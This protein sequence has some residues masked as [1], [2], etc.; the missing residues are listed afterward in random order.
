MKIEE[1]LRKLFNWMQKN[2]F[3][4]LDPFDTLS[5]IK[6]KELFPYFLR[7]LFNSKK[8]ISSYKPFLIIHNIFPMINFIFA[9]TVEFYSY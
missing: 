9:F 7:P 3:F 2:H 6:I 8:L 4:S 1:I 5:F